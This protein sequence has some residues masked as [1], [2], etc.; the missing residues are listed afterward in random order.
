M[1]GWGEC[2]GEGGE[3]GGCGWVGDGGGRGGGGVCRADCGGGG[4]VEK[5]CEEGLRGVLLLLFFLCSFSFLF[6]LLC[7]FSFTPSSFPGSPCQYHPVHSSQTHP[8]SPA[9][10]R[11]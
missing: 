4:D 7:F 11:P 9:K 5:A 6:S 3:A 10:A 2:V 1:C 8:T